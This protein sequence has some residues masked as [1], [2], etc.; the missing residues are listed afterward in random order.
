VARVCDVG[1]VYSELD[2]SSFVRMDAAHV[3]SVSMFSCAIVFVANV[4]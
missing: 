2:F 1:I 4:F 3:N